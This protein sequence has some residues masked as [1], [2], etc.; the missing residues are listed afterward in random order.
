VPG[1]TNTARSIA[2]VSMKTFKITFSLISLDALSLLLLIMLFSS[3]Q[4]RNRVH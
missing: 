2:S 1:D 4:I 3:V